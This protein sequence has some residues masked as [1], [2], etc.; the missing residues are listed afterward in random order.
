MKRP[1]AYISNVKLREKG[2]KVV[3]PRSDVVISS[4]KIKNKSLP[5]IVGKP[6]KG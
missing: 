1:K 3:T 2:Q 4:G 6:P 5:K